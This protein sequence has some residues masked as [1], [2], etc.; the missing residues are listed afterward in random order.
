M[1]D[2]EN[3]KMSINAILTNILRVFIIILAIVLCIEKDYKNM[4]ILALTMVLTFYAKIVAKV[5]KIELE[6]KLKIAITLFIFGAQCLGTVLGFYGKFLWW[7]TMLHTL[8]GVIFFFVGETLLKQISNKEKVKLNNKKIIIIFA[9]CFALSTG[10]FWEIFEFFVDTVFGQN[11]QVAKG[12]MGRDAIMDT[13]IDLI[14]LVVGTSFIA[15]LQI[16]GISK[17]KDSLENNESIK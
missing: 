16:F 7:D 14:S 8:S 9:V 1:T 5:F 3:R 11:M 6:E 4:G 12:L 17:K 2:K 10:V 13:M 15:G